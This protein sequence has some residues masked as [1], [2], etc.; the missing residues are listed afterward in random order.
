MTTTEYTIN[1][2]KSQVRAS[3]SH[4]FDPGAM[5]SFGTRVSEIVYQGPGGVFFVTSEKPPHDKRKYNVRQFDPE[6][7]NI[8]THGEFCV[9]S[10]RQAHA[11][12]EEAAGEDSSHTSEEFQA[13][14]D[15]DQFLLD[16]RTHGNP[17][18]EPSVT[19]WL[20]GAA[21]EHQEIMV[22]HSNGDD[23]YDENGDPL[24]KLSTCRSAIKRAARQVGAA[25]VVFGGDPRGCTVKLVWP[26]GETNDFGK[27]GWCVPGA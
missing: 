9:M 3:G 19:A 21:E 25:S 13:V 14:T 18:T 1:D 12:A 10:R 16:C 17:N 20:Q 2:I 4:W 8:S 5:R 15:E 23:P 6:T 27:E 24:P 11:A 26:D 7:N 22:D